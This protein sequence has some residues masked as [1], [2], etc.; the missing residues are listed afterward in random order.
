M[1]AG[2]NSQANIE[3]FCYGGI[4]HAAGTGAFVLFQAVVSSLSSISIS[5]YSESYHCYFYL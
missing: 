2:R 3:R 5:N 4:A 1:A